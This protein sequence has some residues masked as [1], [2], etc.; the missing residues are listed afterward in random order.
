MKIIRAQEQKKPEFR[1]VYVEALMEL[2]ESNPNVVNLDA[3]LVG[4]SGAT[5]LFKKYAHRCI[6][7]GISEA[8]MIGAAAGMSLTGKIPFIHT[9]AP[10]AT[11]RVMDQLYMSGVYSDANIKIYGSDP[12]FWAIH[13]G[14]T[15]TTMEDLALTRAL[16]NITVLAPSDA[17]QFKWCVKKAADT[18]GVFYIRAGRKA[19]V[20]LYDSSS[21]FELGKGIKLEEGKDVV[22]F[23]IGEMVAEAYKARE[24]LAVEGIEVA[25][26]DMFSI[27]PLDEEI[28]KLMC[29]GKRLVISAE[30]H[31]KYGGLGSAVAEVMAENAINVPL[32]RIAVQD[33]F[34][35]VGT[36]DYLQRILEID[37]EAIVELVRSN[38]IKQSV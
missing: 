29:D 27:K 18:Y 17:T 13:N 8:N 35:E 38:L 23:A 16:A 5:K 15:H 14:G 1:A 37:A 6:N 32:R 9:F 28:I 31:S 7:M 21:K 4:A 3:D 30:N 10:F 33:C 26:V 36:A 12:G 20:D 25:I 19:F 11:R 2:M 24:I 22:I 34:S